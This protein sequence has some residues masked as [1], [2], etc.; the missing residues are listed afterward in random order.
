[1]VIKKGK[2]LKVTR[3]DGTTRAPGFIKSSG[4]SGG[5][6]GG[7]SSKSSSK[8]GSPRQ[9]S[10]KQEAI[11][12]A[13]NTGRMG[14]VIPEGASLGPNPR[15][16]E[17]AFKLGKQA[18]I[19]SPN[20][21]LGN[22]TTYGGL[23]GKGSQI[24][25]TMKQTLNPF[26]KVREGI[27]KYFGPKIEEGVGEL[28]KVGLTPASLFGSETGERIERGAAGLIN[29]AG[30]L[31]VAEGLMLLGMTGLMLPKPK[32]AIPKPGTITAAKASKGTLVAYGA[33]TATVEATSAAMTKAGWSVGE[34]GLLV[35]AIGSYPFAGFINEEADQTINF[36][37]E[38]AMRN[39]DFESAELALQQRRELLDPSK[40]EAFLAKIPFA[41]V[42][43]NLR[44]YFDAARLKV[45]ID[46]KRLMDAKMGKSPEEIRQ[47]EIQ[48][49][50][51]YHLWKIEQNKLY[52]Q[53][54]ED[55]EEDQRDA[56]AKFWREEA[57]KRMAMEAAE[58]EKIALFWEEYRK[59]I[60]KLQEDTSPSNLKFGL[61]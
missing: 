57:R 25:S 52:H 5:S 34:A 41:N 22:K 4:S 7:S 12:Y 1:M 40:L 2:V 46:E 39:N 30:V 31:N 35:A 3:A 60:K 45:A 28:Q 49:N 14:G 51:D 55:A 37:Y 9:W 19:I 10:S 53:W 59:R 6:S 32:P 43:A 18:G 17:G 47:E 33:N 21:K 16:I 23:R 24:L 15:T 42:I 20:A 50:M 38:S 48:T 8:S 13:F 27:N 11:N 29:K 54:A 58:R 36:A 56:D 44:N 61:L 26:S